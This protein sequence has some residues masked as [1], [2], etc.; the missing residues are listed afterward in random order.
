MYDEFAML[1]DVDFE[2]ALYV[3]E[4][5]S[6]QA[7]G[8]KRIDPAMRRLELTLRKFFRAQ[9]SAFIRK[10]RAQL[11]GRFAEGF[12]GHTAFL[13]TPLKESIQPSEWLAIWFE[14]AQATA[15]LLIGPLDQ[16][17]QKAL[18]TGAIQTI[19]MLG[20]RISFS[21][22]NTRA[23][24]YLREYGA[25]R[26]TK[27]DEETRDQLRTILDQAID[28]GWSYDRTARAITDKFEQFA[29]G[30][31]L[32]HIDSRAHLVAVTEIGDAYCEGN[33]EVAQQ[34]QA[35]GIEMEKKWSTVGDDKVSQTI[36]APNEAQGWIPLGDLFQSGHLRP[37]GHPGCRCD[38]LVRR[39][40]SAE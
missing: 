26:V 1:N 16:A 39:V 7:K 15:R 4:E 28:E 36:C 14:V 30:S 38:I 10:F 37:L 13:N 8:R 17:V 22:S 25:R 27:I 21:L 34:L 33:L 12:E 23:A 40:G 20:M 3:L 31:P 9:G 32:E 35:A 24:E 18:S 5:A 6:R 29:V 11:R 2:R 19:A